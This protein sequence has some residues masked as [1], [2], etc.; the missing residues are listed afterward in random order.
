MIDTMTIDAQTFDVESDFM[1]TKPKVN[2]QGGKGV[3]ILNAKTKKALDLSTP[4]ML[5]WG[6]NEYVDDQNGKRTYDMSLQFPKEE[7]NTEAK[8]KFLENLKA[9]E[10]K[11]KADAIKNCKEWMNKP[12]MTAEVCDALWTPM[13][14]YPKYPEGHENAGDYDYTRPPTIRLKVPFW[15]GEFNNVELYDTQEKMLYPNDKGTLPTELVT[16]GIDVATVMRCGGLYFINGKFGVTWK[17]F[18]GVV[19][20]KMSLKGK[21][22]VK[23]SDA[24]RAALDAT[25]ESDESEEVVPVTLAEDSDDDDDDDAEEEAVEAV[26][27]PAPAPAPAPVS[28][29]DPEPVAAPK[30]RVVRKK[31]TAV[32]GA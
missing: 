22:L 10:A 27:A 4:L 24:D 31:A 3:G 16:K 23:L 15:D 11:I 12:K 26:P 21:C 2:A 17:L 1:Y 8:A 13:L 9:F 19:K 32:A 5:T 6:I 7:Y 14:K 29:P 20:P 25:P 18:Q 30:K 28:E